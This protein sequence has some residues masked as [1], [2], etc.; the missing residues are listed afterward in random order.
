M[1]HGSDIWLV[2]PTDM[3]KIC[4]DSEPGYILRKVFRPDHRGIGGLGRF[5]K[6]TDFARFGSR[7]FH[8]ISPK[9]VRI[10]SRAPTITNCPDLSLRF[11]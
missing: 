9:S 4:P 10:G 2:P 5:Q 3:T 7:P 1:N 11:S 6:K 8:E